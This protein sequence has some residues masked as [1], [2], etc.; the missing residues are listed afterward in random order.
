MPVPRVRRV[1]VPVLLLL[2]VVVVAL[3]WS[4]LINAMLPA[5]S[6]PVA[7][8]FPA[9]EISEAEFARLAEELQARYPDAS[10]AHLA[11]FRDAG[12]RRYEGP[13]TCLRCH[14]T[15]TWTAADGT[16]HET[17][18]MDNVLEYGKKYNPGVPIE[19][20]TVRTI[21]A[22]SNALALWEAM[23]RADKAGD[24]SGESIVKNGF[25]TMSQFDLGLGGAPLTYTAVDHRISGKVPIYEIKDGKIVL[26]ET[27]DLKG[28]WPEKWDKEWLGW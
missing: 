10:L 19:K 3:S 12:V 23:K 28:R 1:V 16:R 14:E 4:H 13:R 2:I 18:L 6:R 9:D 26:L 7:M 8:T 24:L 5:D 15:V 11:L 20:R 25:E 27:V 21:Q 22:W 17:D